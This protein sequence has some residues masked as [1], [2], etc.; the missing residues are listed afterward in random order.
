MAF[1]FNNHNLNN[2]VTN[3]LIILFYRCICYPIQVAI[4]T[5]IIFLIVFVPY[6]CHACLVLFVCKKEEYT[7]CL[8]ILLSFCYLQIPRPFLRQ[9]HIAPESEIYIIE[10]SLY[11]LNKY[12]KG[13]NV[14]EVH[15]Q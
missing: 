4:T 10:R 6:S 1:L 14:F 8:S 5:A 9:Q 3:Y 15:G 7:K 2:T 13:T 11:F 12:I